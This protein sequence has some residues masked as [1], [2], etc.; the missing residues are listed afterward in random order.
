VIA[1]TPR[2]RRGCTHRLCCKV[3]GRVALRIQRVV[4]R[5]CSQQLP[6]HIRVAFQGR[7]VQRGVLLRPEC[8]CRQVHMHMSQGTP[9]KDEILVS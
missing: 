9:E 7:N 8:S 2:T 5:P 1:D 3:H 6:H 4:R